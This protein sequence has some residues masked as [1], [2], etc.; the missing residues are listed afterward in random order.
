MQQL[1]KLTELNH[2]KQWLSTQD[3]NFTAKL[4]AEFNRLKDYKNVL[5]WNQLVMICEAITLQ[6]S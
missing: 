4:L 3:D 6:K 2:I 1:Y 5:E